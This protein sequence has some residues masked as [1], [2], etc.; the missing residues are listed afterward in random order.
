[1]SAWRGTY[2]GQE[3]VVEV[4]DQPDGPDRSSYVAWAKVVKLLDV[5]ADR[6]S[7]DFVSLKRLRRHKS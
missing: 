1:M 5:P 4:D 2:E 3:V 6:R 7:P